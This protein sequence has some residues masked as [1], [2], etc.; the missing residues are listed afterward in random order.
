MLTTGDQVYHYANKCRLPSNTKSAVPN[1]FPSAIGQNMNPN[2]NS[3]D[4]YTF[5]NYWRV[6]FA[7]DGF[8]HG[9]VDCLQKCSYAGLFYP[10]CYLGATHTGLNLGWTAPYMGYSRSYEKFKKATVAETSNCKDTSY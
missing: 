1:Y 7:N 8:N 2:D 5:L 3:L 4:P 9:Q 10:S 6:R